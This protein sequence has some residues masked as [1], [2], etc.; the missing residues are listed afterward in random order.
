MV[1]KVSDAQNLSKEFGLER[2]KFYESDKAIVAQ[3]VLE[4]GAHLKKHG[5]E[6]F[7]LIYIISGSIEVETD[8]ETYEAQE[9]TLLEFQPK[10]QHGF[11]NKGDTT[12]KVLVVR[13]KE[14]K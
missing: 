11:T 2:R 13:I 8:T 9:G 12:A 7:A 10:E 14:Q 4:P 1:F 6:E 5:S 3:I